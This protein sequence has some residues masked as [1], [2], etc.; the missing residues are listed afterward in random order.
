[1][2]LFL[3]GN[4]GRQ[5]VTENGVR[6]VVCRGIRGATTVEVNTAE[7]ILEAT[8]DLLTKIIEANGVQ[9]EDICSVLFTT[10]VDVTAEYPAL[11]ARQL[12]WHDVALMCGHE[13]CVPGALQQCIRV[14]IHW[15][16]T[17]RQNEIQHVYIRGAVSLRPDKS[18]QFQS[19]Q[20]NLQNAAQQEANK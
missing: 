4:N 2:K 14:L 18:I 1:V 3:T 15:N 11:A 8:R 10:T 6:Q 20:Q 13:M 9:Q 16:T 7:A 5:Q 19:F 17:L 12:G